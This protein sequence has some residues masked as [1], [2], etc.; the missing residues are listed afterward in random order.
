MVSAATA[1][2]LSFTR[3]NRAMVPVG[4]FVTVSVVPEIVPVNTTEP[5]AMGQ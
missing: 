2:P 5:V 3:E 4:E 1:L